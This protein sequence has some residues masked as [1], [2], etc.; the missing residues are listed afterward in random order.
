MEPDAWSAVL[1]DATASHTVEA[2]SNVTVTVKMPQELAARARK[3]A[4]ARGTSVSDFVRIAVA[5]SLENEKKR[6]R[7][8]GDLAGNVFGSVTSGV[9]DLGS[10]KAHL[11]GFGSK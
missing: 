6:T 3:E 8:V 9:P 5:G 11:R 10:N 4:R 1:Q 7:T 2:M